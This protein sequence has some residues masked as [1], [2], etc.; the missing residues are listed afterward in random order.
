MLLNHEN[1]TALSIPTASSEA[2]R[3]NKNVH[4][5]R[6]YSG[7]Y[8]S[9]AVPFTE[10]NAESIIEAF[11]SVSKY[12]VDRI[13]VATTDENGENVVYAGRIYNLEGDRRSVSFARVYGLASTRN[14]DLVLT[15]TY[16]EEFEDAADE[17]ALNRAVA[18]AVTDA[19]AGKDA[20]MAWE[21]FED[22]DL[23]YSCDDIEYLAEMC[24][25]GGEVEALDSLVFLTS[26][27]LSNAFVTAHSVKSE[28]SVKALGRVLGTYFKAAKDITN[29][30]VVSAFQSIVV[31]AEFDRQEDGSYE[32]T[33]T[34]TPDVSAETED[35]GTYV[36]QP[37]ELDR[38]AS[39][40]FRSLTWG[41]TKYR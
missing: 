41:M 25:L 35:H 40:I 39:Y 38:A 7:V 10:E 29:K 32:L 8:I 33:L 37:D 13:F 34:A 24:D 20:P 26:Y 5:A 11:E 6:R 12:F 19:A 23:P 21:A 4:V 27:N 1:V 22:V 3:I 30:T 9:A 14:D 36:I 18:K 15:K 31:I 2:D 17:V 28:K 16:T